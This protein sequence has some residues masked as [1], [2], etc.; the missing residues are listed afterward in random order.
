M[1]QKNSLLFGKTATNGEI[2]KL[3]P[4]APFLRHKN[5]HK[6][7]VNSTNPPP[8]LEKNVT[9]DMLF[10]CGN[11]LVRKSRTG[12]KDDSEV[13]RIIKKLA[14]YLRKMSQ[15]TCYCSEETD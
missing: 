15:M 5:S 10:L 2:L 9:N 11:R 7:R 6:W 13:Q 14:A 4:P 1:S 12:N 3:P 8:C